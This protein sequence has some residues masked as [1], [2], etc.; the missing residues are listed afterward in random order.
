MNKRVKEQAL[1]CNIT[2]DD[3]VI[4]QF[5]PVLGIRIERGVGTGHHL[6]SSPSL[7]RIIPERGY[8]RGNVRVVSYRAN[9]L[10]SNATLDELRAILADAE[11]IAKELQPFVS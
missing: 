7:D 10:K 2:I 1:P 5:C 11:A 3:I 4:P 6:P 9:Q 8:T